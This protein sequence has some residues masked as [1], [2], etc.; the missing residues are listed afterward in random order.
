MF[1]CEYDINLNN[2]KQLRHFMNSLTKTRIPK[3][4][5]IIN[6][7]NICILLTIKLCDSDPNKLACKI[8]TSL[9]YFGLLRNSEAFRIQ[10][11]D[12]AFRNTNTLSVDFPYTSKHCENGFS[13][14][15]PNYLQGSFMTYMNQ[16]SNEEGRLL[17]NL[18]VK[19]K[20]REQNMGV[21]KAVSFCRMIEKKLDLE[22]N[23]LSTHFGR[24][25]GATSLADA[26]ISLTN[27]KRAGRWASQ[28]ACEE[29]LDHSHATKMD[30][31]EML[32]QGPAG[33]KTAAAAG[34]LEVISTVAT[35]KQVQSSTETYTEGAA[36]AA[37][38]AI[39]QPV[40]NL[41]RFAKSGI[42]FFMQLP[43][44]LSPLQQ[45][46][47]MNP[48]DDRKLP[49]K[50]STQISEPDTK[51][52]ATTIRRKYTKSVKTSTYH[53]DLQDSDMDDVKPAAIVR[54]NVT[55]DAKSTSVHTKFLQTDVP[56]R[57]FSPLTP[58]PMAKPP[59]GV[60]FTTPPPSPT[61]QKKRAALTDI[62]ISPKK[63][64]FTDTPNPYKPYG[65]VPIL[66]LNPKYSPIYRKK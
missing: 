14:F 25:S 43:N 19:S 38:A 13:F 4:L 20:K 64:R 55:P 23:S 3:K 53:K 6:A 29:Y 48:T 59:P 50:N 57:I 56:V 34:S 24:R 11:K 47:G 40:S 49:A 62:T 37:E 27:L 28:K 44:L 1:Q 5:E 66:K 21:R 10:V 39:L 8:W 32:M 61:Y 18:H 22:S 63:V 41:A 65:N 12:V 30:R 7:K 52:R 46:N 51:P 45:E 42:K 16:I 17:K 58:L 36:A 33:K 35:V 31:L 15:I 60:T 2:N 9:V 54:H 26:G